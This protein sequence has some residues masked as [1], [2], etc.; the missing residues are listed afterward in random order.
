[1][2]KVKTLNLQDDIS[3]SY[4]KTK[5]TYAGR[6]SQSTKDGQLVLAPPLS[7]W[8]D[9]FVGFGVAPGYCLA[10]PNTGRK[11]ELQNVTTAAPT[12]LAFNF[13]FALGTWTYI[14]KIIM[15]LP[16]GTHAYRGFSFD[17][18]DTNNIK[19]MVASSVTTTTCLGGTYITWGVP[20]S[21]FTA[22]G[23]TIPFASST[24]SGV[25]GVYFEQYASQVG[26][27]H[28]GIT[29]G[30]VSSGVFSSVTPANLTKFWTQNGSAAAMQI[31]EF[32]HSLGA[33]I[34]AGLATNDVS[35]Q[36]TPF[37]GTSPNA[38]FSMSAQNGYSTLANTAAAF[39]SIILQNG[40]GNVPANF[41]QTSASGTQTV[42]Y[43]R[44]LQLVSGTW[45]FNLSTTS[46]GAAVVPTSSTSLFTMMR[47]YGISTTHSSKKTGNI[48]PV[49]AG[50][51]LQA[52]SFGVCVPASVPANPALNNTDCLFISTSSNLY[53]GK[54]ND[55]VDASAT[56]TSITGVNL[57]GNGVD[58]TTP[59]ATLARYSSHLDRWVYVTNTS[60]FVIKPHQNN[61]INKVMGGLVNKYYEG[62]NP[63]AVQPG[64][65]TVVSI[66][67]SGGYLFTVG[68]TTG[69]RGVA[70]VDLRSDEMFDYSYVISAVQQIDP[71]SILRY[72][73]SV[74]SY[75]DY[76]DNITVYVRSASTASDAIFNTASGGWTEVFYGEDNDPTAIGP[77]F[78]IKFTFNIAT[79]AQGCPAQINDIVINYTSSQELSEYLAGDVDNTSVDGDTPTKSAFYLVK[80]YS[81]VVPTLYFRAYD[82]DGNLVT[83]G[84][85]VS[86]PTLFEYSTNGGTSWN[87]LGTIPNTVGTRIR[88][89]W[90]TPPGVEVFPSL[91][92]E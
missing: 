73:S 46:T 4:D 14:G 9:V 21:D 6:V 1:M 74:E 3:S 55:L 20:L 57:L 54:I 32:D 28:T 45:Y 71:G 72:I 77:Y 80:Q 48:S 22:P 56:W 25:K 35:A 49:L 16:A 91:R 85:T 67:V 50:T 23:T 15:T 38:Y 70:T 90:T 58:I 44:D 53:M 47:A 64:L 87:S 18:S 41:T 52:H 12:I 89:N 84:N 60:K 61:V 59:S 27:D 17:D 11:F 7:S 34:A 81:G 8:A 26:R 66:S 75:F 31:Y 42:Y 65:S 10:N 36:T 88:Y 30:G 5:T 37:G 76:T 19:I 33:P 78:Q 92:E 68:S 63:I 24:T 86:N 40:T 62:Q 79:D 69:Q 51:L 2:A 39:E 82:V 29:A 83:S 13:D 43:L